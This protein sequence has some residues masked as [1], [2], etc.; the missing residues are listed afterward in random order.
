MDEDPTLRPGDIV[1]TNAGLMAYNGSSGSARKQAAS[2][3]PVASYSGLSS[4]L[5]RKL[6]ETKIAP[7]LETPARPVQAPQGEPT[8]T[9]RNSKNKRVQV[10]R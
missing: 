2:Y 10:D 9:V 1:A 5:R 3:T 8:S 6:T 4:D 7:A